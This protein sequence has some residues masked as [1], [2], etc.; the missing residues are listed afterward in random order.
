MKKSNKFYL[1]NSH[2]TLRANKIILLCM[3]KK[4]KLRQQ[5]NYILTK[6]K[7]TESFN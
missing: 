7:K 2:A 6:K 3:I 4:K 1:K 5:Q